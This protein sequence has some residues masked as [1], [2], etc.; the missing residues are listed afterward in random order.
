MDKLADNPNI[1]PSD[2]QSLYPTEPRVIPFPNSRC[3]RKH[4]L[5]QQII[6]RTFPFSRHATNNTSSGYRH[7]LVRLLTCRGQAIKFEDTF[8]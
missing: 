7:L 8:G 1:T 2:H 3:S 6:A 5:G 4:V